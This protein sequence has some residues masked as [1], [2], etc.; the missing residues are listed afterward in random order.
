VADYWQAAYRKNI[1]L[2]NLK[3]VFAASF[4]ARILIEKFEILKIQS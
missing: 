1:Q 2:R 4:Q 3:L